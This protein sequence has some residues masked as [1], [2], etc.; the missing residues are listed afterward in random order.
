MLLLRISDWLLV[1]ESV[2][3]LVTSKKCS[4]VKIVNFNYL[5]KIKKISHWFKED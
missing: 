5:K 3:N 2:K 1:L 4:T